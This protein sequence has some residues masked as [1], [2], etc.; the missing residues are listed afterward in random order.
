MRAADPS[1]IK[2]LRRAHDWWD[3]LNADPYLS[4]SA[5]ARAEGV[6]DSYVDPVLRLAFLAPDIVDLICAGTQPVE[7]DLA[8]LMRTKLPPL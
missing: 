3:K 2:A 6:S 8:R 1:I 4:L 5:L 7:L